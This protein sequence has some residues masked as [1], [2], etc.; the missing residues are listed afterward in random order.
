MAGKDI[1]VQWAWL[2]KEPNDAGNRILSCSTGGFN[3]KNF[4]DILDRFSPGTLADPSQVAVS[5]VLE[6]DGS[7]H[8]GMAI[9]EPTAGGVDRFGRDVMFVRYFCV[10]YEDVAPGGV[11]YMAMHR[12]L[13]KHLLPQANEPPFSVAFSRGDLGIPD[14]AAR[15]LQVTEL[16]LTGNPVCIV[17]AG[18]TSMEERLAFID[19]VMRLLPYGMRAEMAAA[20]WTSSVYKNHKF[21]LFFSEAPRKQPDS[22]PGDHLVAWRPEKLEVRR[23]LS[24]RFN[25]QWAEEYQD[26]LQPLLEK[27]VTERLAGQVE[28]RSFKA[29]D[30]LKLVE[31]AP[32]VRGRTFP[33]PWNQAQKPD[34]GGNP[35][36]NGPAQ[37]HSGGQESGSVVSPQPAV[38]QGGAHARSESGPPERVMMIISNFD[39]DVRAG[40]ASF[41][42]TSADQLSAELMKNPP[43]D[44]QRRQCQVIIKKD[45]LLR[46]DL[47]L[48]KSLKKGA[49]YK[50]L[51]HAAFGADVK[52]LDY[53]RIEDMLSGEATHKQLAQVI[54]E[55]TS[56]QRLKFIM[57]YQLSGHRLPT[58][59]FN[60]F[61]LIDIAADPELREDHAQIIWD[62]LIVT[63]GALRSDDREIIKK[64]LR[65]RGFL[66]HRLRART[67]LDQ[68]YQATALVDLLESLYGRP[69]QLEDCQ[70]I[71]TGYRHA[72]TEALLVAALQLINPT[73][74]SLSNLLYYFLDS[75]ARVPEIGQDLRDGFA[76]LGYGVDQRA[77]PGA[78]ADVYNG[79]E[80]RLDWEQP[81]VGDEVRAMH[82]R[83]PDPGSSRRGP[84]PRVVNLRGRFSQT[85]AKEAAKK[86][87]DDQ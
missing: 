56:D 27:A 41:I 17:D 85:E 3:A 42:E 80:T 1:A 79:D 53:L 54:H 18:S 71:F 77:T 4:D 22:G 32:R 25:P 39:R 11:S 66:A 29:A 38:R 2:G 21:R 43:S 51:L 19:A 84:W 6:G 8:L 34:Q 58:S 67:P 82:T 13:K 68:A 40:N 23:A 12:T 65:E 73:E 48:G 63:L 47:Q 33:W 24:P 60:P 83:T 7:R 52:Y 31:S 44:A 9:Y 59:M 35:H 5:Y 28:A 50:V 16:L 10:P 62:V 45:R 78:P 81:V 55:A 72:P 75:Y 69:V 61:P 14:D 15:A 37:R 76:R 26:W 46:E 30:I 74:E 86:P 49:F 36:Q 70:N 64:A 57:T 87:G 20:T